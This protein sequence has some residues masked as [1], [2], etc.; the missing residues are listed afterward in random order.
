MF[1]K[2]LAFTICQ[3]VRSLAAQE[4]LRAAAEYLDDAVRGPAVTDISGVWLSSDDESVLAEV[5]EKW[6]KKALTGPPQPIHLRTIPPTRGIVR[7]REHAPGSIFEDS[8]YSRR[9]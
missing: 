3:C 2:P 6:S 8:L 4:Y 5:G 1:D 9:D 7:G